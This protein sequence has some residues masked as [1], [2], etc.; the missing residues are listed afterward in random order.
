MPPVNF[1]SLAEC[2]VEPLTFSVSRVD[3]HAHSELL[4]TPGAQNPLLSPLA[5]TRQG[6]PHARSV[7]ASRERLGRMLTTL[8]TELHERKWC[9]EEAAIAQLVLL[10]VEVGRSLGPVEVPQPPRVPGLVGEALEFIQRHY[11]EPLSLREVAQ[12]FR[13]NPNHLTTAV[14]RATGLTVLEWITHLRMAEARRRLLATDERV[15]IIAER[16]GYQSPEHFMRLFRREHGVS[17][18]QW[19]KERSQPRVAE[20]GSRREGSVNWSETS[21][22]VVAVAGL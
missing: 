3:P 18:T 22:V 15:E 10:L 2:Q 13:S 12:A 7:G 1:F 21:S 9:Y 8:D 16:V 6:Y 5:G 19:R 4:L 20:P 14:R 17:P 11:T